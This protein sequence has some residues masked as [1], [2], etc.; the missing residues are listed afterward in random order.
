M[1]HSKDQRHLYADNIA[2]TTDEGR[3]TRSTL[4]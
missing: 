3:G 2:Q 4:I 1:R